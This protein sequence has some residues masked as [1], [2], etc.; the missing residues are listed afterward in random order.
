MGYFLL[1]LL[2][3]VAVTSVVADN[4]AGEFNLCARDEKVGYL[5]KFA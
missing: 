2:A 1:P 3:L 5:F 4:P